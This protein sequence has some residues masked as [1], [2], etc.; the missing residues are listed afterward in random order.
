MVRRGRSDDD[1]LA[2]VG[3]LRYTERPASSFRFEERDSM[4]PGTKWYRDEEGTCLRF[5]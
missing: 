3:M 2:A 1:S 4:L 5:P